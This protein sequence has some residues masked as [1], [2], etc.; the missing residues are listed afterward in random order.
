LALAT[1][2]AACLHA[3][4]LLRGLIGPDAPPER[5]YRPTRALTRTLLRTAGASLVMGLALALLLP[6]GAE[7]LDVSVWVRAGWLCIGVVSGA[8]L[9][10]LLLLATGERPHGLLHR[11]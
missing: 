11:V 8:G 10:V 4:L 2:A 5:R 3:F 6:A 9:Y 1:S 7:W